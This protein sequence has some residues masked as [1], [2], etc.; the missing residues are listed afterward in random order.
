MAA[1]V[2]AFALLALGADAATWGGKKEEPKAAA[3][4]AA[5][6]AKPSPQPKPAKPASPA[7]EATNAYNLYWYNEVTG[8]TSVTDPLVEFRGHLSAKEQAT[9]WV[10]PATNAATWVVPEPYAWKE[11]PSVDHP[12]EVYYYNSV[13]QEATWTKP[14]ILAWKPAERGFWF[15]NVTGV[16]SWDRPEALGHESTEHAGA[17]YWIADDGKATWDP[18]VAH[19]WRALASTTDGTPY[20]ENTKTKEVTWTRPEALSWSRRSVNKTYW[21]NVVTGE[22]RRDAP[23]DLVGFSHE[24]GHVYFLTPS[25]ASTWDRPA[26]AAWAEATSD[27][28][29]GRVYWYNSVTGETVWERPANSNVAW[30]MYHEEL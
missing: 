21:W 13:T 16:S 28:H 26:A 18:P 5:A 27:K 19:A 3:K 6:A 17:V 20:F 2:L 8:E 1:K 15:N 29:D 11:T 12:G 7:P 23:T 10:D 22:A 4:A 24:S 9:Y 25:G 30:Q 14:A